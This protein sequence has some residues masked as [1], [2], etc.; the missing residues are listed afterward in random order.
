MSDD[1]LPQ[2]ES[3][4]LAAYYPDAAQVFRGVDAEAAKAHRRRVLEKPEMQH[5]LAERARVRAATA[6]PETAAAE[7]EAA[8]AEPEAAEGVREDVSPPLPAVVSGAERGAKRE[9]VAGLRSWRRLAMFAAAAVSFVSLVGVL[10]GVF[11]NT[12]APGETTGARGEAAG[13]ATGAPAPA[14]AVSSVEVAA[15]APEV[16]SAAVAASAVSDE[17]PDASAPE[18]SA[19]EVPSGAPAK[20]VV[21]AQKKIGSGDPY[22]E[23]KGPTSPAPTASPLPAG[24]IPLTP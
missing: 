2:R 13:S 18:A 21:P 16:S 7:P 8:A 9:E 15:P 22:E 24:F 1:E 5:A 3:D 20:R 23:P 6:E 17:A 12:T 4:D 19:P 10:V 11:S 14:P